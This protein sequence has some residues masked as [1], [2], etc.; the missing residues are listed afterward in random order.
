MRVESHGPNPVS[1]A[2]PVG[3]N[4]GVQ[5][6]QVAKPP[7]SLDL[8]ATGRLVLSARQALQSVPEVRER[9]VRDFSAQLSSGRY[10]TD[11]EAVATAMLAD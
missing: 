7:E 4:V 2:Q 6:V 3:R 8:S 10:Q 1:G 11:P 5:R 9:L